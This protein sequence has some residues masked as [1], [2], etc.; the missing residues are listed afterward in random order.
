MLPIGSP[1]GALFANQLKSIIITF[2]IFR[3]N[4]KKHNAAVLPRRGKTLVD[5]IPHYNFLMPRR[6]YPLVTKTNTNNN[7]LPHR[8]YL[9]VI[10]SK[11]SPP[12]N[13]YNYA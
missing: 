7:S 11:F 1:S 2:E 13:P 3:T 10:N 5:L 12:Q 4:I 8:G 9:L 6:G